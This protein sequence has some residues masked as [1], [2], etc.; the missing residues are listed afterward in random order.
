MAQPGGQASEAA[1]LLGQSGI[2]THRAQ[3]FAD[4]FKT[5]DDWDVVKSRPQA[6]IKSL[7]TYQQLSC[8]YLKNTVDNR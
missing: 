2:G 4:P 5:C 6:S 3:V 1:S 8:F 7:A